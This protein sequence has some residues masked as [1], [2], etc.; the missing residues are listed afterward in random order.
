MRSWCTTKFARENS[1]LRASSSSR[2][3]LTSLLVLACATLLPLSLQA[4]GTIAGTVVSASSQEPL[5]G[6]TIIIAG[7]STRVVSD[8]GGRFRFAS[9]AGA[10]ATL[11]VRRIGYALARVGARVGD[12]SVRIALAPSATSLDA[13]VVTGVTGAAQKRELG[14]A[15]GQ[16]DASEITRT[17]PIMSMQ[18]LLNGRS[19]GVVIMPTAGT[20]GSGSQIR[21]RG[22]AS[23][24]LGN[25]PLIFVDGV[26]VD[27]RVSTG[28]VSQAFGSSPISRLNDFNT[29]DIET[30]EVLKGPSAATLYG[31]EAAN[32]VINI[33]TKKG[34]VGTP[35]WSA[36]LKQGVNYFDD[37]RN[38]FPTNYGPRRLATDPVGAATGPIE[39][40]NFDSL[41]IGNCG[42]QA[43]IDAGRRCDIYRTGRHQETELSVNGGVGLLSYYASGNLF[44]SEGA[45]PR[46]NR[47]TYNG[48]LNVGFAASDKFRITTN[49]GYINGPTHIP[50]D[51]GCGGYTWTTLSATP[52]N[53]NNP[54]R[55]GYHSSLPYEYDQTVV[56]WQD[57]ARMTGSVRFEHQPASW[58]T[59]RLLLGGDFTHEGDNEWDPRVDSLS[60]LGFRSIVTRDVVNRSLDYSANGVWNYTPALRFTT[61]VGAQYFTE[62]IHAVGASG[63]VFATPGLK[64]VTATTNR[65]PPTE[66]FSDDKSFGMYAQEQVAWRDRLYITG[67]L[68]S[69]DHSAF[70]S[71]F[72]RVVYPKFSVSYVLSDEPWF[73]VPMISDALEDFRL[74]MAYGESGKAPTTYSA[75]RTYTTTAGPGDVP[76]VTPNVTGNPS[77]GPE[78]GKE[79]EL[80]FDAS[81]LQDRLGMELTYYNK[82]TVDAILDKQLAP[83]SGQAGTQPFNIGGIVNRGWEVM[84]RGTPWRSDRLDVNLTGQIS[85]NHNEV[86]DLGLPGQYFVN[87]GTFLRH[88]VGYPAFGWFEQRIVSTP[89]NRTTGFPRPVTGQ[90]Y[91]VGVMCSDTIPNS[92]GKEGGTPRSCVG[93]DGRWGTADDAPNVFLGRSVPPREG[94]ISGTITMFSRWRVFSM[95]DIK[96]GHK[97]MDGNTRVRCGIFGRCKET[98]AIQPATVTQS[99]FSAAFAA[100]VDSIRTA[101]AASN[102]NLVDFLITNSNYAKWRELTV[103]YDVPD[104]FARMARASRATIAI[105]GRNLKTWTA[106]QGFEPEAMF[107]GGSRGGNASWEQ[108][109]LPQLT[110]WMVS[111]N[112]GF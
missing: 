15:I 80:G 69:D 112:F 5:A 62:S 28:P 104:R 98:F 2:T 99:N 24:S 59:Q 97:K 45:E 56:L 1:Q 70:G 12:E 91:P 93:A 84:I 35:R 58:F 78:K 79:I 100:E 107:L 82:K 95:V 44:D 50:C 66:G 23:L 42:S 57:L 27:N 10:T 41:L 22:Q 19:P 110:S 90:D 8:D 89:F 60:S 51:A 49:V 108:T 54:R 67:A 34:M 38:R 86:S 73:K 30:I 31:T 72:T 47:R 109:T 85:T 46:N 43:A 106:Y 39:A 63:S 55:H 103:A 26:R 11:E 40:L 68:R 53:Y 13:V 92:G 94:S 37:Y 4:Q 14:N 77:L 7:T 102:S 64:S 25:N 48:R 17:A 3:L 83:S 6:A 33:I 76:A 61:A 32:G 75:I 36:A 71:K 52:A 74:R 18:S 9:V 111:F 20:V 81:A 105:S 65:N 16:I 87:A 21:I 96:N 101:Q 29:N 88:Q